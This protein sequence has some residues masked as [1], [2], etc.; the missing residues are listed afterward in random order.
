MSG[1]DEMAERIAADLYDDKREL[2]SIQR[3]MD[4]YQNDYYA[5]AHSVTAPKS[6]DWAQIRRAEIEMLPLMR[7]EDFLVAEVCYLEEIEHLLDRI[8]EIERGWNGGESGKEVA[9]KALLYKELRKEP[10][11]E[12]EETLGR[13]KRRGIHPSADSVP[14]SS[15][16][17]I[18]LSS[19]S[20]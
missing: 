5:V 8:R 19:L 15:N 17:L 20:C 2:A 7:S 10:Q 9:R 3:M 18:S 4:H 16:S 11:T 12:L 13:A 6:E 14:I 1:I